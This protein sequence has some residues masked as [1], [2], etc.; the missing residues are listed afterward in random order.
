MEEVV[1]VVNAEVVLAKLELE[2]ELELHVELT[3]PGSTK[4]VTPAR[5]D[6]NLF[7]D[8]KEVTSVFAPLEGGS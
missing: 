2:L 8:S 3:L 6:C 7:M 5:T 4:K 1:G